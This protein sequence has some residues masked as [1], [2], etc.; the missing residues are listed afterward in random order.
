MIIARSLMIGG[1][2]AQN[3]LWERFDKRLQPHNEPGA[4]DGWNRVGAKVKVSPKYQRGTVRSIQRPTYEYSPWMILIFSRYP[5]CYFGN[6]ESK[7]VQQKKGSQKKM[8]ERRGKQNNVF[9]KD[10]V[11][12]DSCNGRQVSCIRQASCN[13]RQVCAAWKDD[14]I[15]P[16][17]RRCSPL[18]P[19]V[20]ATPGK[21]LAAGGNFCVH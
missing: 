19:R 10:M 4:H 9:T 18:N 6:W 5:R 14:K 13:G 15:E 8:K 16:E 3:E 1:Y 7:N 2:S 12:S 21:G 20:K 11:R 17:Q